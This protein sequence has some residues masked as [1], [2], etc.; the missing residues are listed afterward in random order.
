MVLGETTLREFMF[1]HQQKNMQVNNRLRIHYR[2]MP[3]EILHSFSNWKFIH[4]LFLDPKWLM[5]LD[6][7]D[8]KENVENKKRVEWC[9]HGNS[10]S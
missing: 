6:E 2:L 5:T 1:G 4:L 10:F 8:A 3:E 7:A 9:F